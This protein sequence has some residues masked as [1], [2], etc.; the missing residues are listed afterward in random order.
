MILHSHQPQRFL[1]GLN[2]HNTAV[3]VKAPTNHA[4]WRLDHR[5]QGIAKLVHEVDSS[6]QYK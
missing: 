2:V 6:E 4:F 5:T 3:A 1:L